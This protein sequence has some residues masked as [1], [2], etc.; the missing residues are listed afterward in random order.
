MK[1]PWFLPAATLLVGAVTGYI[2][3][4][5]TNSSSPS[6]AAGND[7]RKTRSS[8]RF[9]TSETTQSTKRSKRPGGTDEIS[10]LP[11]SSNRVQALIEFYSGLTPGQLED[12]A[13]KLES[14]PMNE[15]MMA[16]F[17]LFGRWAEVDPTAAMS[18]SST[19]GFAGM[20]V[21]PTILQ[22]WASMDPANAAKYYA[23]NPREFAMMGM[24]GGGRGPMG[25]QAGASII[26][27]EW[28]RQDPA[29]AL[30][31]A[32][33]LTTEKSQAMSAV[34]G[35]V[36]KTDP[37]KAAEMLSAM[38]GGDMGAAYRSVA[39][40]YGASDFNEAQAW[41]RSLPSG[42]QAEALAAA[43]GGLSNKN[44]EAAAAQWA[45]MPDGE[46]KNRVFGEVIADWAHENA[47]AAAESIKKQTSED[48]QREG[49]RQLMPAWVGLDP[50]A[51]RKYADSFEPGPV[52]DSA[53]Q[54]Y[55]WSNQTGNPSDLVIYAET[56]TDEG[57]RNRSIGMAAARWMRESPEAAKAY[58]EQSTTLPQDAKQ[59]ILEGRGWG[60]GR[61]RGR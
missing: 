55:I 44:P 3:G 25:G 20:F 57:D 19:M 35:E 51:A 24:M 34:V 58:V 32:N 7:S 48:I 30:A 13:R 46:A 9:E 1:N 15:R 41:I 6:A 2:F 49:M 31:W 61:G 28:A 4:E 54:F 11:G 53:V 14:L 29:A 37:K 42:E 26:A 8:L 56:I 47:P 18:F 17:L 43:I 40:Q 12:E 45:L 23:E 10:R 59:R 21:R 52:R 36:A 27:G 50:T 16:S 39:A 60:G 22:S 38:S 33:S 5:N